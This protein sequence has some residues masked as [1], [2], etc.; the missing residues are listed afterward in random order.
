MRYETGVITEKGPVRLR[1]DDEHGEH[2]RLVWTDASKSPGVFLVFED[3][4]LTRITRLIGSENLHSASSSSLMQSMVDVLAGWGPDRPI[5]VSSSAFGGLRE[6]SFASGARQLTVTETPQ[7]LQVVENLGR[8]DI[9]NVT[10]ESREW[11]PQT[12]DEQRQD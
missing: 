5:T 2:A 3:G 1:Y 12:A 8:G 9:E 7:A 4:R 6:I 10:I 11:Q